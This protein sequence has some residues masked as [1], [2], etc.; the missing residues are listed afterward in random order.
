MKPFDLLKAIDSNDQL[1]LSDG[2][3]VI[4]WWYEKALNSI[5]V[6]TTDEYPMFFSR[7]GVWSPNQKY[8]HPG[9]AI[10]FKD[11]Q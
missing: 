4:N 5:T 10:Y 11:A 8:G 9:L 3:E 6:S 7:S 1:V 2:R